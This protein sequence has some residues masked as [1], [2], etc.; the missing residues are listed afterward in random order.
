MTANLRVVIVDDEP[1]ALAGLRALLAKHV[2]IEIVNEALG[3]ASAIA[4]LRELQPDIVILDVQMPEVDG[5]QVLDAVQESE[6]RLPFVIFVTAHDQ[7]AVQAFD[8]HAVDYLLKPVTEQR[9]A[10]ALARARDSITSRDN[11]NLGQRL[12]A[13]LDEHSRRGARELLASSTSSPDE[14]APSRFASRML[15][16]V[17]Q[18]DEIVS[19]SDIDWIRSD[20]YCSILHIA[21]KQHIIRETLGS[22]EKKLDPRSFARVHRSVIVNLSRVTAL[23]RLRVG[24]VNVVLRD[25]TQLPVSRA[26]R[27]ALTEILGS[28]T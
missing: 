22:L 18:R 25:G 7:F 24:G 27:A 3:G 12:Q 2:D 10:R 28:A 13:L 14:G 17:G 23:R 6:G 16:R 20:D 19:V 15:V 1:P 9:F 8:V 26:R 4:A 5:F 21:G 11:G